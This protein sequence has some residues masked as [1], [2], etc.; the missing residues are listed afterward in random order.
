MVSNFEVGIISW[1]IFQE[2]LE[3]TDILPGTLGNEWFL[4]ALAM[5]AERPALIERLFQFRNVNDYGVYRVKI[6]KNG[7][8]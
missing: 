5:L 6:C 3:P 4:Q 2:T 8:W 1:T 7:E